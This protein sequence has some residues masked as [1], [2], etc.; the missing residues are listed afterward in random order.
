M[1]AL[2]MG[3]EDARAPLKY[4]LL[5]IQRKQQVLACIKKEIV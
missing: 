5:A 1:K 4:S 3:D 2:K